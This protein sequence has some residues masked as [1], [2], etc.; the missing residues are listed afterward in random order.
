M[1]IMYCEKE[2]NKWDEF[3]F[4]VMMVYCFLVYSSIYFILNMMVLGRN[5]IMFLEI[6]VCFL[7]IVNEIELDDYIIDF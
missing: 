3:L 6:V 4:Q 5:N 2:Q 1:F 7:F